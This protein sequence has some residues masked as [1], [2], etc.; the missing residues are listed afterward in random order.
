LLKI[1][2]TQN[3]HNKKNC[4]LD[5]YVVSL[6]AVLTNFMLIELGFIFVVIVVVV[7]LYIFVVVV[8]LQL[9]NKYFKY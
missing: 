5:L 6:I 7:L 4:N 9:V 1:A 8:E 2:H 3:N